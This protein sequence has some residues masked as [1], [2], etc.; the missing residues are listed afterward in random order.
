MANQNFSCG[1]YRIRNTVTGE[2]YIG[3]S[4]QMFTRWYSHLERL[5]SGKH[6]CPKFQRSYDS[7]SAAAFA[8]E[9][10]ELCEPGKLN[11]REFFNM[12]KH[13]PTLNEAIPDYDA[14]DLTAEVIN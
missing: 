5:A 3:Q 11:E 14:V 1:I 10:L 2:C 4:K 6:I 13:R 8:F 7:F 12:C 9:I